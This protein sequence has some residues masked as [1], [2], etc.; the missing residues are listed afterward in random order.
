MGADGWSA[1]AYVAAVLMI[2]ILFVGVY[3]VLALFAKGQAFTVSYVVKS[4]SAH[5]PVIPL[6]IGLILGHLL[7]PVSD[8]AQPTPKEAVHNGNRLPEVDR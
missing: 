3:D 8:A 1:N 4:W 2:V 6:L 5:F 7:W